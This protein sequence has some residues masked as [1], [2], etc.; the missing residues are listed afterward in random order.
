MF[1][2]IMGRLTPHFGLLFA[3]LALGGVACDEKRGETSG[4][5]APATSASP[6]ASASGAPAASAPPRPA[7]A[8]PPTADA[9]SEIEPPGPGVDPQCGNKPH[10]DCPLQAWMKANM[11]KPSVN[12]D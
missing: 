7:D 5:A 1:C 3:L 8:A 12:K 2:Q 10:P 4:A 6:P 11:A 9:A